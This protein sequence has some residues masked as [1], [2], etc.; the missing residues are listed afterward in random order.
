MGW[1]S[2]AS[3]DGDVRP[4]HQNG[5]VE[6]CFRKTG[7]RLPALPPGG[8]ARP[9]HQN[10]MGITSAG[11]KRKK[12]YDSFR[13]IGWGLPK[14]YQPPGRKRET[15]APKWNGGYLR[16]GEEEENVRQF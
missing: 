15:V 6:D 7:W 14:G 13:I 8:N 12:M 16:G 4:L 5:M 1:W 3:P 2:P 9:L 10:G 11:E